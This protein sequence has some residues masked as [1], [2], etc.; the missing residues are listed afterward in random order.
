VVGA[1]VVVEVVGGTVVVGSGTVVAGAVVDE[2][3]TVVAVEDVVDLTTAVDAPA[4]SSG[5]RTLPG[6]PRGFTNAPAGPV[7]T[8]LMYWRHIVAG[9][10]P[11]YTV[12]PW[13][14]FM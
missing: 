5:L 14:L 3:G 2:L 13:T 1:G 8:L 11:P 10:V 7:S 4:V 12:M 6:N 9:N